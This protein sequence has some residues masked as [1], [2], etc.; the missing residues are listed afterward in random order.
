MMPESKALHDSLAFPSFLSC[1][2]EDGIDLEYYSTNDGYYFRPSRHWCL[3]AE[4]IR[5]E[6]FIRLRLHV[7][8]RAGHEFPVAFHPE[9]GERPTPENYRIGHTIAILYPHQHNF[10]D[11][12]TGIRQ[13]D[14]CTIQVRPQWP[15]Q[16]SR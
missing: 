6:F 1:P 13:E 8:D 5:V 2:T 7:R 12:T 14:M 10:M 9:G 16:T 4:V 15:Q 11:M 3:L